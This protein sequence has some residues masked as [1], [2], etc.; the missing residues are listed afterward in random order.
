M[1]RGVTDLNVSF[2]GNWGF[3][4]QVSHHALWQISVSTTHRAFT[5][6]YLSPLC[7]ALSC[8]LLAANCRKTQTDTA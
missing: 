2:L 6:A 3:H 5:P 4:P 7:A 8:P 1:F